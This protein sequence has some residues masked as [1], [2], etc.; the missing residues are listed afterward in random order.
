MGYIDDLTER[1]V[2][3]KKTELLEAEKQG[4]DGVDG[5]KGRDLLTLI[6]MSRSCTR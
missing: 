1:L 4:L 6:G 2:K 5:K 3:A